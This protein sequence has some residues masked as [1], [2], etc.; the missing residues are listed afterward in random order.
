MMKGAKEGGLEGW[1]DGS[2]EGRKKRSPC[3]TLSFQIL[4]KIILHFQ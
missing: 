1:K 3:S 2:K 4:E